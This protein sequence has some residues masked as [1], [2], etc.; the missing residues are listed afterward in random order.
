MLNRRI[1]FKSGWIQLSEI[2]PDEAGID[3]DASVLCWHFYSGVM[4][5]RCGIVRGNRFYTHWMKI[6][7][8]AWISS[9]ERIPKAS[10]ADIYHCVLARYMDGRVLMT[11]WRRFYEDNLLTDW[12]R[13][14][15]GP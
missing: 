10:D 11:G 13:A 8:K 5:D 4:V 14:P 1:D 15:D 2:M 3:V 12:Q 6:N 9:A 7:E